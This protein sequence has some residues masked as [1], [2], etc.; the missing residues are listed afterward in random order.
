MTIGVA[1]Q[2][3]L[4][5]LGGRYES[6]EAAAITDLVMENI[7]GLGKLDRLFEKNKL[8]S[9]LMEERLDRYLSE[10]LQFR[11][12]QYV[13][14]EA[15]FAGLRFSV[16]EAVLIPRPET[17]ELVAWIV[18]EAR[19]REQSNPRVRATSAQTDER[20]GLE[21]QGA[22]TDGRS[23]VRILDIGT[24]SGCIAVALKKALPA[25]SVYGCEISAAALEVAAANALAHQAAVDFFR[26][27]ILDPA[28]WEG[29]PRF[30]IIVS[31]PP[32]IPIAQKQYMDDHVVHYE[33]HQ[34][35]FVDDDDPLQF[36][37]QIA[38]FARLHLNPHGQVYV[39]IHAGS[40]DA[41]S[42]IFNVEGLSASVI[43][44][45]MQGKERF[46]RG[47]KC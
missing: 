42:D 30:D 27:D 10:L 26:M 17:E 20:N 47:I 36:Y 11:P 29:Q 46:V 41:V 5:Q 22:G 9:K 23:C 21:G 19:L 43:K 34:A 25:A 7:T 18:A 24:G 4:S 39:E 33:P 1:H 40:G 8:L 45:D 16:N 35:L 38:R 28:A 32:Y 3:L 13:L 15:W 31:N 6:G 14:G 37:R 12:I 44:K 2:Q